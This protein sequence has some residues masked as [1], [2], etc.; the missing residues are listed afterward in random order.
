[1]HCI[2]VSKV[3][4]VLPLFVFCWKVFH[5]WH[6]VIAF[7]VCLKSCHECIIVS[8]L[9]SLILC[10]SLLPL[11]ANRTQHFIPTP[12]SAAPIDEK[13]VMFFDVAWPRTTSF[14][15]VPNPCFEPCGCRKTN[16]MVKQPI[17][18]DDS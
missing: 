8:Y 10:F 13:P 1:M 18:G 17:C 4:L 5:F 11:A 14:E 2:C 7:Y 16:G 3:S 6:D 15:R 9:S 12:N